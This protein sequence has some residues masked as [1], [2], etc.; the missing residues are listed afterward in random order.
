LRK[1]ALL[2]ISVAALAAA[3]AGPAGAASGGGC[4][5]AGNAS[6]SPGLGATSRAFTYS[7]AG[8]LT[9][10]NSTIAGAPTTGTVEA[11][12]TVTVTYP[13]ADGLGGTHA[14][15]YQE[16]V[17]SGNGGCS[18][19]TTAGYAIVRWTG[20]GTTV[21]KYSTSGAAAAVALTGSVV[22]SVTASAVSGAQPGDPASITISS[23]RYAGYSAGGPLAFQPPDPTACNTPAGV[24]AAGISGFVGLGAQS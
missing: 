17:P 24:T 19:S 9:G 21:I 3:G 15:T 23:D 6:F 13:D 18:N 20:G 16:P 4:Q 11:G 8:N 12:K 5:L 7:F 1:I 2:V 10:C 22:P 14:V